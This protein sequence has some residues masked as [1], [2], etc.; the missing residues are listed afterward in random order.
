MDK[1]G[2]Q[3]LPI[4]MHLYNG[5]VIKSA[6]SNLLAPIRTAVLCSYGK[7]AKC[8]KKNAVYARRKQKAHLNIIFGQK[9]RKPC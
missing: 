9:T 6:L 2:G 7:R 3:T 5:L 8:Q 1:E 4:G